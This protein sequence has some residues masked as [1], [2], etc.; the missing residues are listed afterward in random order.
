MGMRV[1]VVSQERTSKRKDCWRRQKWS[2]NVS[3][4]DVDVTLWT[5][6]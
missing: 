4:F 3:C 1:D 5:S 2:E 6:H